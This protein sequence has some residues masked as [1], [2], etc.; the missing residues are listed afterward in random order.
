MNIYFPKTTYKHQ[1]YSMIFVVILDTF[2]LVFASFLKVYKKNESDIKPSLNIYEKEGYFHC[3]F[4]IIIFIN[5][6]FF[7]SLCRTQVK[8]LIDIKFISPYEIIFLIGIVGFILNIVFC[9]YLNFNGNDKEG[10]SIYKYG[11]IFEYFS[12][13]SNING[14]EILKEIILTFFFIFFYFLSITCEFFTIKYLNPN[15]IL[16]SDNIFYEIIRIYNYFGAE[17][18]QELSLFLIIQL[19]EFLELIGCSI[20]LE[21]IELRFCGLNKNIKK[22]IIKRAESDIKKALNDEEVIDNSII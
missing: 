22:N 2:L 5:I 15:Y 8:I 19:A 4:I 10:K 18:K 17:E 9:L 11:D 20:Y 21:I 1:K 16:M 12:G 13:F 3:F 7:I 14:Y 6:T